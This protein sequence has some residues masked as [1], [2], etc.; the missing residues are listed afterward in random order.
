MNA[1]F[2]NERR[3]LG[4]L[5]ELGDEAFFD[6]LVWDV[7]FFDNTNMRKVCSLFWIRLLLVSRITGLLCW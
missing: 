7:K 4:G 6:E 1:D 5:M 2:L 3:V